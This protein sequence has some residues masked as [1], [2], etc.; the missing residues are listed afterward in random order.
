[1]TGLRG[2]GLSSNFYCVQQLNKHTS[3][4]TDPISQNKHTTKQKHHERR[5]EK[6]RQ[7]H[8]AARDR[9]GIICLILC[10]YNSNLSLL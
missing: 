6:K 10:G 2:L 4:H 3:K 8:Q 9:H 5:T 7:E 1:M